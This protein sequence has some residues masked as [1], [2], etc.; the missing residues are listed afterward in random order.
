M[1]N[2]EAEYE[3]FI[4]GLRL[5]RELQTY[6]IRI[7]SDSQLVANQVSDIYLT[8][9]DRMAAYLEK[10]KGLIKTF[11][12]TSIEVIPL[13]K[14]VNTDALT[15]LASTR[16][17]KLLD[18]V[19]IEFL[20]EPTIKPQPEI[21]ELMQEPSWMDPVISYLKNDELPEEKTKPRILQLKATR[22]VL[23]D[24]KLYRTGY[25]MPL[26]TCV[27]PME[28]KN[29][30]WKIHDGTC[31]NHTGGQ[32]LVFKALRQGY[33]WP[34]M[35]ADCMEYAYKCDKCQQFSQVSKA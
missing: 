28:A 20:A 35:N 19:S 13:F 8:G 29:I 4:G 11:R 15:K 26:L 30:M 10:A 18:V 31:G 6:S 22:Y 5:A 27:L 34:I 9:G 21:M 3:A 23:Y 1:S 14:N 2:N 17:S 32:S 33:Y 24:D 16:D 12:I 7:Y 25:S